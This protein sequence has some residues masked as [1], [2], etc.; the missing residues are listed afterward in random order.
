MLY[1]VMSGGASSTFG[2]EIVTSNLSLAISNDRL[3]LL[4][5]RFPQPSAESVG[6]SQVPPTTRSFIPLTYRISVGLAGVGAGVAFPPREVV[7]G[8]ND[9]GREGWFPDRVRLRPR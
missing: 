7:R 5:S 3:P 9:C 8:P 1:N 6:S 4:C 2:C